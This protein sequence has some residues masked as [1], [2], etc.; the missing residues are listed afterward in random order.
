MA[1]LYFLLV[2]LLGSLSVFA[3]DS[4]TISWTVTAKKSSDGNYILNF[5]ALDKNGWH[6]YTPGQDLGDFQQVELKL[7]D[8]VQQGSWMISGPAVKSK[9]PFFDVPS[10]NFQQAVADWSLPVKFFKHVPAQ[11]KGTL[12]FTYGDDKEAFYP[13]T[14]FEFSVALE[15]GKSGQNRILIPTIDI[16][17][18]VAPCGDETTADKSAWEVFF[19]G[20]GAGFLALLF[21]CI[22]PLIPL[23]VSFF[24]KRAPSR[25]QGVRNAFLYGFSIFIIYAALSLPFHLFNL[26]PEV[27]NNV[28]TNVPLN[29]AFFVVFVVL[30]ISFFGAFEIGLPSGLANKADSKSGTGT[31][32][33]IFFMALTLA[34]VSFSCTSG[35]LGALIA[36][37]LNGSNAAWQLTAGMSGFGIGLGVPFVLFALF[38][39]WLRTLPKS[40]GWMTDLKVVFGFIELAMAIK[41]LS[42][43]DLVKHWGI[44][45]REIFIGAWVLVGAGTVI[46]LSGIFRKSSGRQK[47]GP[48]R[49]FF[50]AVF[51]AFTVYLIPGITNTPSANLTLI[52]GFP[53]PLSYSVY[54]H[55][56]ALA[57]AVQPIH[58]DY[59]AA[60]ELARTERKPLLIDFTGD[61]CVNCRR[62]EERIWTDPKVAG[63]MKNNFVVVSL[64]VDDRRKLPAAERQEYTT[65]TG[66]KRSINTVGDK[67]SA[68]QS[69]NFFAVAQ[70]QY[71]IISPDERALTRPKTYTQS[72][73]DFAKWLECGLEAFRSHK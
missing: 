52:S 66:D 67:W 63:Y 45:P 51:A 73:E 28:A 34:V 33:G 16:S 39:G 62:M 15:G 50:V 8:S 10:V 21:P 29:L 42:N 25:R 37:S 46:Y 43:A 19:L 5:R 18:P 30:A 22:Y 68:F 49:L 4:L 23:T 41:F 11:L 57:N 72:A 13:S 7:Q 9:S 70:P 48:I 3:Q 35:I 31:I 26:R 71:M 32:W 65:R 54:R 44:L 12:M 69:E 53:P 36:G 6:L 1:R 2:F 20:L 38:P 40:G 47:M 24:T 60:L 58:N 17:K 64:Y 59:E 55:H 61:A 56:T 27:L 14:P